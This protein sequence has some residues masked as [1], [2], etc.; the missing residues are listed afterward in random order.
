MC[1]E[2]PIAYDIIWGLS[3][4]HDIQQQLR[5]NTS[6]MSKL[7]QVQ[8]ESDDKQMRK[9]IHGI[10]WN[11]EI[12]S[13]D[14]PAVEIS[15]EKTFD[16]MISYSHKEKT[17]CKQLY[18]ELSKQ[19][20]HVWIDFDQIHGNVMDTMAQ[21]IDRSHTIIICMSEEYQ[22]S[23][24]CRAEA[25]YAFRCQ[26]KTVPILLQEFYKP[27]G[28]LLFLVSH[29]L[30]VDFVKFGFDQALKKLLKELKTEDVG[31]STTMSTRSQESAVVDI[32]IEAV[33]SQ[34]TSVATITLP[35]NML[36]WTQLQVQDWLT[37][38]NLTEMSRLL[39]HCDGRSLFYL[40]KYMKSSQPQQILSLLQED[41]LRRT[42]QSISLID[43]SRFQSLMDQQIQRL[44]SSGTKA[45]AEKKDH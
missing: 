30:Y 8:K 11:L 22:K 44:R 14:V 13:K 3:F 18:E 40:N 6:F 5:S 43:I 32:P 4:N 39:A 25:H 21:A 31:E 15:D 33:S 20:Y 2:F 7:S 1:D 36:E 19:G 9:I 23:N 16:I 42:N 29:L 17:V 45:N 26:R 28:W 37:E 35:Q 10:L 12:N 38:H 24:Y 27:H 41:S 34:R